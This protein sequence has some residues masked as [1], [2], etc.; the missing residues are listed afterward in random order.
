MGLESVLKGYT[1]Q[2]THTHTHTHTPAC[3]FITKPTGQSNYPLLSSVQVTH[4]LNLNSLL[5]VQICLIF[6]LQLPLATLPWDDCCFLKLKHLGHPLLSAT[7]AGSLCSQFLAMDPHSP[8]PLAESPGM[9]LASYFP[10]YSHPSFQQDLIG[11]I[12]PCWIL[13][14]APVP[15]FPLLRALPLNLA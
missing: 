7:H 11:M 9:C 14:S 6:H 5:Y 2:H 3:C 10:W 8:H 4:I 13:S 12:R 1:H 15:S